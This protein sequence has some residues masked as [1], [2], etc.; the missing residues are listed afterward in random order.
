MKHIDMIVVNKIDFQVSVSDAEYNLPLE[1]K[2]SVSKYRTK[3]NVLQW[4]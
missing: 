4:Y 3:V 1:W 2:N